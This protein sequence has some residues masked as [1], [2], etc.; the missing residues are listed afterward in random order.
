MA[1]YT[2]RTSCHH[3]SINVIISC[4]FIELYAVKTVLCGLERVKFKRPIHIFPKG[5]QVSSVFMEEPIDTEGNKVEGSSS[6]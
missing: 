1:K 5:M 6:I 4:L 3:V 2:V